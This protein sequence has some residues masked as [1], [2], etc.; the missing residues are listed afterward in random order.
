MR[1]CFLKA[2]IIGLLFCLLPQYTLF[3]KTSVLPKPKNIEMVVTV[4]DQDWETL[5]DG[6]IDVY[7]NGVRIGY[8]S[9][10]CLQLNLLL[11]P[12]TKITVSA[13]KAG[14]KI[15]DDAQSKTV[16]FAKDISDNSVLRAYVLMA[17]MDS[18]KK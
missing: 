7:V 6:E 3:S 14:Y 10:A 8:R 11:L 4:C 13:R 16:F 12:N 5:L 1:N 15:V 2:G 17:P 9:L 18:S